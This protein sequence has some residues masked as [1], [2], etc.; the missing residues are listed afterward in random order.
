MFKKYIYTKK[1]VNNALL[2]IPY[3]YIFFLI[4]SK[5]RYVMLQYILLYLLFIYYF[6]NNDLNKLVYHS[7]KYAKLSLCEIFVKSLE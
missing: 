1:R 4:F 5:V 3:V 2:K 7:P 6:I